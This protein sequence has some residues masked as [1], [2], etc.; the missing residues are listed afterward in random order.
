MTIIKPKEYSGYLSFLAIVFS[1]VLALGIFYIF[2]YNSL[3]DIRF[4]I[5][6]LKEKIAENQALNA[7]LKHSLY[8]ITEPEGFRELARQEGLV[9]EKNPKFL[10][11]DKWLSDSAY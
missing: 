4:E 9:L 5:R 2:E 8:K 11:S 6:S 3:V 7:D 1:V 10:S